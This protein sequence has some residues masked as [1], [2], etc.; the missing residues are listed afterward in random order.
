M[1]ILWKTVS[2]LLSR[3]MAIQL[4]TQRQIRSLPKMK[5]SIL[6]LSWRKTRNLRLLVLSLPMM[7]LMNLRNWQLIL[8]VSGPTSNRVLADMRTMFQSFILEPWIRLRKLRIQEWISMAVIGLMIGQPMQRQPLRTM[9]SRLPRHLLIVMSS[10][11]K[12]HSL[13]ETNWPFLSPRNINMILAA[14]SRRG[15]LL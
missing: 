11:Q 13:T 2:K 9:A 14:M 10:L 5:P 15:P 3:P 7:N 1:M 4:M 6:V 12:K 8:P